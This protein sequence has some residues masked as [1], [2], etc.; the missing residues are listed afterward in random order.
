M[1]PPPNHGLRWVELSRAALTEA[2]LRAAHVSSSVDARVDGYGFGIDLVREVAEPLGLS[3]T[4]ESRDW[5]SDAL[6]RGGQ[7]L[8]AQVVN[9]KNVPAGEEVSYGGHFR[10]HRDTTLALISIGF[11]DGV[12]RLNPV[13]G[14]VELAG[15]TL[16]I[17][18]RIAMD[19]LIV[20]ATDVDVT[21]GDVA[22]IW[23]GAVSVEQ[24]SEWS[25]RPAVEIASLLAPRVA[26]VVVE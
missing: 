11:A 20:D 14:E 22:T 13:G 24:W 1:S 21:V 6:A 19:Q 25:S 15:T 7:R 4:G 10:T 5:V 26:R 17:A 8:R 2:L 18:G 12:P 23:G 3:L 9:V 16:P